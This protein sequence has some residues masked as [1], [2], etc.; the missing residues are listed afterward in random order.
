MEGRG[1]REGWEKKKG[2]DEWE[3]EVGDKRR[4]RG[5]KIGG[6]GRKGGIWREKGECG[7]DRER[8]ESSEKITIR[9]YG[10]K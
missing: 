9:E 7:I 2:V 10:R 8:M 4:G 6:V 1:R 5:R 3:R